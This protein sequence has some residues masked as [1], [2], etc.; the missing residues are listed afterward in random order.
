MDKLSHQGQE[1]SSNN[2]DPL[3]TVQ[4]SIYASLRASAVYPLALLSPPAQDDDEPQDTEQATPDMVEALHRV[5]SEISEREKQVVHKSI[6]R[7]VVT[8]LN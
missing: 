3:A 1:T 8:K 5:D 4:H 7:S 2:Q 6:R